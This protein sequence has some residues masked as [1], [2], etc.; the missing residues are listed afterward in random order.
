MEGPCLPEGSGGEQPPEELDYG[1]R[2]AEAYN[3]RM[4]L[5]ER[6]LSETGAR[7]RLKRGGF[8]DFTV[9]NCEE[10]YGHRFGAVSAEEHGVGGQ[11]VERQHVLFDDGDHQPD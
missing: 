4:W 6:G 5:F 2:A 11:A 7:K 8:S 3:A 9:K 10:A 1:Q